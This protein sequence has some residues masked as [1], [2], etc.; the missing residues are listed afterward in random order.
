MFLN[1]AYTGTAHMQRISATYRNQVPALGSPFVTY[2]ASYDRPVE[3]LGGGVGINLSNDVQGSGTLNKTSIDAL[4]AYHLAL[5]SKITL[6]AG[7]Q[8]SYS[9]R[10]LRTGDFILPDGLD[11]SGIYLGH[12]ETVSDQNR[13]YPDFQLEWI[14]RIE[15]YLLDWHTH[16]PRK[17][18]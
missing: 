17:F 15:S 14:F 9:F 18:P 6:S 2:N 5:T 3:I 1:P 4:Y 12:M 10:L 8:A 13:G 16:Q 11:Q 7:F